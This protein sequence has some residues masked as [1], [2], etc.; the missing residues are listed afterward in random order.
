[1]TVTAQEL[2]FDVDGIVVSAGSPVSLTL[3]GRDDVPYNLAIYPD[4]GWTTALYTGEIITGRRTTYGIP[5]LE[6]GSYRFR[7]DVH[8]A[9]MTGVFEVRAA[10]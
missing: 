1:M 10:S 4:N 7:C 8:P 5:S 6:P 3:V 2:S 9:T